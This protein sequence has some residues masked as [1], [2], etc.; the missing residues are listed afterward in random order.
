MAKKIDD[1]VKKSERKFHT[2]CG[3]WT[4]S[5]PKWP[6][7]QVDETNFR[8]NADLVRNAIFSNSGLLSSAGEYDFPDGKD[9]GYR[10]FR[11]L[12]ADITEIDSAVEVIK[13]AKAKTEEQEKMKQQ[14]LKDLT[15]A[16]SD[17]FSVDDDNSDSSSAE[18]TE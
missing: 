16:F 12:G 14:A 2:S 11:Q 4:Y 1:V 9:T 13:Q 18:S 3:D 7:K 15:S 5:L 10:P 17:V 8:P 6:V